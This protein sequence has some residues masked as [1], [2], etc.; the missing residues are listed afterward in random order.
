MSGGNAETVQAYE[1][2]WEKYIARTTHEPTPDYMAW[3]HAALDLMPT[4]SWVLEIGSGPGVDALLIERAGKTVLRS[5]AAGGFVRH[6]QGQG[7]RAVRLNI[8][9]GPPQAR[10]GMIFADAVFHHFGDA[11]LPVALANAAAGLLPGGVLA[12]AVRRGA[13]SF[14]TDEKVEAPRFFRYR[15]PGQ[16]WAAL[17]AA[18]LRVRSM[19]DLGSWEGPPPSYHPSGRWLNITAI[20]EK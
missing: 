5:D 10:F 6:L 16:M 2:G 1:I 17:E 3:L 18:G 15:E 20:R 19:G 4:G 8:L 14:W 13:A 7:H 12:L 9:D 11:E